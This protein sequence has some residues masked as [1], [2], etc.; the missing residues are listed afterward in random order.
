MPMDFPDIQSVINRVCEPE[1]PERAERLRA[2]GL[3]FFRRP[4]EGESEEEFRNA[5]ADFVGNVRGDSVEAAEIRTGRGW[6]RQS[7][8]ELLREL[9]GM[10]E[11]VAELRAE[12]ARRIGAEVSE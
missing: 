9:P 10:M 6:D 7:P 2:L 4:N 1:N 8:E 3:T 11:L 5:A 12:Q